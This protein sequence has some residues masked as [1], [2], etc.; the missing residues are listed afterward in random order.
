M[1]VSVLYPRCWLFQ[2]ID[3]CTPQR[4]T[5]DLT[6]RPHLQV[7]DLRDL[8]APPLPPPPTQPPPPPPPSSS[9]GC[10]TKSSFM[11]SRLH[12]TI[13]FIGSKF[14]PVVL[15]RSRSFY[16]VTVFNSQW[17]SCINIYI[18]IPLCSYLTH[19]HTNYHI[20]PVSMAFQLT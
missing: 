6:N 10:R 19:S 7:K 20:K 8:L 17:P 15:R 9:P 16:L 5:R 13:I 3:R 11:Q 2:N 18:I 12:R 14:K 1:Y 4:T